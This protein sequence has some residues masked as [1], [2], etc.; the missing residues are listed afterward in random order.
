MTTPCTLQ[1]GLTTLYN[2]WAYPAASRLRLSQI[3]VLPPFR[4]AGL[5]KVRGCW[6]SGPI[7]VALAFIVAPFASLLAASLHR[8]EARSVPVFFGTQKVQWPT[9]CTMVTPGSSGI[10]WLRSEA[11]VGVDVVHSTAHKR[12]VARDTV[13]G[14][15]KD[16]GAA[17]W[18]SA[19][20]DVDVGHHI[21][22]RQLSSAHK[23]VLSLL[24]DT[25][26][27]TTQVWCLWPYVLYVLFLLLVLPVLQAM[28]SIAYR[29][30]RDA[31]CVDLTIEDPTPNLQVSRCVM[32]TPI[33]CVCLAGNTK[34][35]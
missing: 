35:W 5:G 25:S 10:M 12:L 27:G 4:D 7:S 21:S 15:L 22:G 2:F 9:H 30:A 33:E 14:Q 24:A 3:L 19:C 23:Q 28:L 11:G 17:C 32:G 1:L 8:R 13:L 16:F 6:G 31:G 20:V 26:D 18:P 34:S 29:M